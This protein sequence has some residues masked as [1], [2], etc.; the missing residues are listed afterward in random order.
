M[1]IERRKKTRILGGSLTN[2]DDHQG[3]QGDVRA[4]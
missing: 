1:N 3:R 2:K 4:T